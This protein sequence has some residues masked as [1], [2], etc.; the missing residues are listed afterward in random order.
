M[1]GHGCLRFLVVLLLLLLLAGCGGGG[2]EGNPD[3]SGDSC[4]YCNWDTTGPLD[5]VEISD[6]ISDGPVDDALTDLVDLPDGALVDAPDEEGQDLPPGVDTVVEPDVPDQPLTYEQ[7]G[8]LTLSRKGILLDGQY[9]QFRFARLDYWKVPLD[10][11]ERRLSLVKE[12]GFNGVATSACWAHHAPTADVVDLSTGNRNLGL[13]LDMAGAQGLRVWFNAGPWLGEGA[14]AG[15]L[16]SWLLAQTGLAATAVADGTVVPREADG[17]FLNAVKAWFTVLNPE[18]VPRQITVNPTNPVVFYQVEDSWDLHL[19]LKEMEAIQVEAMEGVPMIAKQPAAGPYFAA[20]RD[21]ALGAGVTVPIITALTGRFENGGR[22]VLGC[23]DTPGVLPAFRFD[24]VDRYA[25]LE[26]RLRVLRQELRNPNLHGSIYSSTPGIATAVPPN[27]SHL[28]RLLVGGADVV[29]TEGFDEGVP[30]ATLGT[31]HLDASGPDVFP[32]LQDG[33][34]VLDRADRMAGGALSPEGLPRRPWFLLRRHGAVLQRFAASLG[35]W[36]HPMRWGT[37][38]GDGVAPVE[39]L[40]PAVGAVEGPWPATAT[41]PAGGVAEL[42][43]DHYMDWYVTPPA[44][45]TGR[46]TY[47]MQGVDGTILVA[48]LNQDNLKDGDNAGAREDLI[49]KLVVGGQEIPRHSNLVVPAYDRDGDVPEWRGWGSKLVVLNHPLGAGLP[50]MEYCSSHIYA[51]RD[52]NTRLLLVTYGEPAVKAGG[53]W[54]TEPGEVSLG[55]FQGI[56]DVTHNT[57]PGGGIHTDPGGKLAIQ[58]Q[59]SGTGSLLLSLASGGKLQLLSTTAAVAER[60]SFLKDPLGWDLAISGFDRVDTVLPGA[61]GGLDITGAMSPGDRPFTVLVHNE[62]WAV[63]LDGQEIDCTY[64]A[65][66]QLLTCPHEEAA[67]PASPSPLTSF[68]TRQE[69]AGTAPG[70][71]G[72]TIH[73]DAFTEASGPLPPAED[74]LVAVD[75]GV[76]WYTTDVQLGGAGADAFLSLGGAGDLV[77]VYVNDIYLGSTAALGARPLSGPDAS[78]GL[79]APGFRIPASVLQPG[80]NRIALR[81]LVWGRSDRSLPRLLSMVPMLDETLVQ[82]AS[83]VPHLAVPGLQPFSHR[84]AWGSVSIQISGSPTAITGPWTVS[85]G[86][87]DRTGR[88][89]GILEG[90]REAAAGG[91]PG[92]WAAAAAPSEPGPLLL[93]DGASLWITASFDGQAWAQQGEGGI[94]LLLEGKSLAAIGWVNGAFMGTWL[95]DRES[96]SQGAH[97]EIQDGQVVRSLLLNPDWIVTDGGDPTRLRLPAEA[98]VA[99]SNRVSLL[100]LDLSPPGPAILSLPGIG[101]V[102]GQGTLTRMELAWN[103]DNGADEPPLLW[104]TRTLSLKEEPPP[105]E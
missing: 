83:L 14:P 15:C 27:P 67:P 34:P 61:E 53:V 31:V 86:A 104:R 17:D 46:S 71:L 75:G 87:P 12:A 10:Q 93:P 50:V 40:N 102:A 3:A 19:F 29:V 57:L 74:P 32:A 33:T 105:E 52:F 98:L 56:P 37:D 28:L 45:P 90:W 8:P 68:A 7:Y 64:D 62:P 54:F 38:G 96:A 100:L 66:V 49:T 23:G 24:D 39:V 88:T 99:G 21:A 26:A 70:D 85:T 43:S 11:W 16:P 101:E 89:W 80:T 81:V 22:R 77:S 79:G 76:L 4:L 73:P 6:V 92:G 41:A 94:D 58:S 78:A 51:I 55:Q 82:F 5:T 20:L 42:L 72:A 60:L 97:S 44:P 47:M 25:S 59:H 1:N 35:N 9:V 65:P 13:F 103:R 30:A 84:G 63:T 69:P 18:V 2:G 91:V 95:S 36:D 48:L